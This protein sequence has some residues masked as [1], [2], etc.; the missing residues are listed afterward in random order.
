M[1]YYKFLNLL[2]GFKYKDSFIFNHPANSKQ[3]AMIWL[4]NIVF[5]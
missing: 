2:D 1:S 5:N 4:R 3:M